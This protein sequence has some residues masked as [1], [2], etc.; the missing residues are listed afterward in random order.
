MSLHHRPSGEPDALYESL[1]QESPNEHIRLSSE[2]EFEDE[3]EALAEDFVAQEVVATADARVRWIYFVLGCAVLLPWNALITATP[4]FRSRLEG[5]SLQSTFASYLSAAFTIANFFFLAHATVTSNQ[6]TSANRALWSMFILSFLMFSLTMSTYVRISPGTFFGFVLLNGIAQAA[7]GS[8][9]QTSVV[10][11][12]SLFGPAAMQSIMSGQAAVGVAVSAVQV[13]SSATATRDSPPR[14]SIS[15]S[16]PEED[17]A[18]AFFGI[19]TAFFLISAIA[20]STLIGLPAYR[21]VIDRFKH[22]NDVTHGD[23]FHDNLD[24]GVSSSAISIPAEKKEQII[25]V[26][27]ANMIYYIAV[28]YVFVVTLSVFPPITV[29]IVSTNPGVH[30]LLFSAFHFFVFNVGDFSGRYMCSIQRI[31]IWSEKRLFGL[32]LART[33]FIPLFLMCNIQR[34]SPSILGPR[35]PIINSDIFYMFILL[36][37]GVS[38]GYISSLC[39]MAA[40]SVEHNPRL[41]GKVEDVDVAATLANFF[42]VGGLAVGSFA[43]FGVSAAVCNCNPFVQ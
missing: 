31:Q 29:L 32:S 43:S 28:A 15:G 11:V 38:N 39:M 40:P 6:A 2:S 36:L 14:P 35:T 37:F 9:L 24:M 4:F 16:E 1:P 13:I 8:Y 17:S 27:K 20:Y 18:F 26:S 34:S 22:A 21:A 19:S 42:L 30:P 7:A 5:S 41:K 3:E 33:L 12:A 25:R 23:M 10:A